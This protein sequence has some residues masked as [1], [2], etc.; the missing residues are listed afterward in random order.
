MRVV[1]LET[2][3]V[4]L[5]PCAPMQTNGDTRGKNDCCI[6]SNGASDSES[7]NESESESDDE[8]TSE[9]TVKEGNKNKIR[10]MQRK[11]WCLHIHLCH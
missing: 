1:F 9:V 11:E 2:R 6:G 5:S 3:L 10:Q 4:S 8:I 7:G